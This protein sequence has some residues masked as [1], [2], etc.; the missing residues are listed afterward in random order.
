MNSGLQKVME[1]KSEKDRPVLKRIK[2]LIK[3]FF[4]PVGVP[5]SHA[6]EWCYHLQL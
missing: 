2:E 6:V 4:A 5:G 1:I 3:D